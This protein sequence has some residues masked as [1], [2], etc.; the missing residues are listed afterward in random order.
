MTTVQEMPDDEA[1]ATLYYLDVAHDG[2]GFYY[3]DDEYPEEGS[4]GA[5][6]TVEEAIAHADEV[7]TM[8][9]A[10]CAV[11]AALAQGRLRELAKEPRT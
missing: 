8:V 10:P 5:F 7:Y 1:T 6:A 9:F 3:V 2:A 4:C 11:D